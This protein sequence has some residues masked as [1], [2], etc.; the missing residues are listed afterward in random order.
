MLNA[1]FAATVEDIGS[2]LAIPTK[3]YTVVKK[4]VKNF[5]FF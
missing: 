5:G 3:I 1:E 4:T 2:S